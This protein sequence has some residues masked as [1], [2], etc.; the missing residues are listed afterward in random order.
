MHL[1]LATHA[2]RMWGRA[3]AHTLTCARVC[4]HPTLVQE[5]LK[6][7]EQQRDTHSSKD[8]R[9]MRAAHTQLQVRTRSYTQAAYAY[10]DCNH[11]P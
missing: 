9:Q 2:E 11:L 3:R 5:R 1:N 10:H 7:L 4:M 8:A 6:A